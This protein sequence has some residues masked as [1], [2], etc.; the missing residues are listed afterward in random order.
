MLDLL[1]EAGEHANQA[2]HVEDPQTLNSLVRGGV[3][4]HTVRMQGLTLRVPGGVLSPRYDAR[5]RFTW[6]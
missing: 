4:G 3:A 5:P 6:A 1:A 2:A